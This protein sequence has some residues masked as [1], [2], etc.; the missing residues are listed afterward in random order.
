MSMRVGQPAIRRK[1][2]AL[3]GDCIVGEIRFDNRENHETPEI[4]SLRRSILYFAS[5]LSSPN[6]YLSLAMKEL[7]ELLIINFIFAHK[8]NFSHLLA[9]RPVAPSPWQLRRV[10]EFIEANWDK[11][12]SVEDLSRVGN[13]SA[14]TLLRHFQNWKA[15]TPKDFVKQVRLQ[16]SRKMLESPDDTTTVL[17]VALKCGFHSHGH[18]SKDYRMAFAELPSET[19]ERALR[20]NLS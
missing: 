19:L 4:A 8:H 11:P 9:R 17:A 6:S 3:I 18:F 2:E 15:M 20:R 13:A 1:M 10:E 7:Q 14:R 5:E 16:K 12:I